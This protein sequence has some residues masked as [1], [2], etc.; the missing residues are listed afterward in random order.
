MK[1]ELFVELIGRPDVREEEQASSQEEEGGGTRF[2]SD[3]RSHAR[4][5]CI[6]LRTRSTNAHEDFVKTVRSLG[7][8]CS[9]MRW[10]R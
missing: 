6:S 2:G 8:L 7:W 5:I 3:L 4:E 10:F 1:H 9:L